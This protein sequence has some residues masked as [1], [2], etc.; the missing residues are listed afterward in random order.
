MSSIFEQDCGGLIIRASNP[1]QGVLIPQAAHASQ[2]SDIDLVEFPRTQS[3]RQMHMKHSCNKTPSSKIQRL[4]D[5]K[6]RKKCLLRQIIAYN[7]VCNCLQVA[8]KHYL[9]K[10]RQPFTSHVELQAPKDLR[11][12]SPSHLPTRKIITRILMRYMNACDEARHGAHSASVPPS[13]SQQ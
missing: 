8:C 4:L 6:D 10:Q 11:P 9:S 1:S 5:D 3:L 2:K 7:I 13:W 12:P